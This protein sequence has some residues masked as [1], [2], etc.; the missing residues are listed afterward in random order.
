[1]P[2]SGSITFPRKAILVNNEPWIADQFG[3]L[4]H[5]LTSSYEQY[6]PNSPEA[7]GS[8]EM[9]VHNNVFYGTAGEVND[10]W[11]Y[12]FNGNGIFVFKA[13]EWNN[14]NKFSY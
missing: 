6:K 12:Q 3:G 2:A 10:A 9:V 1:M 7:I 14:I 5:Q 4:S 11:N 8:G 13:G